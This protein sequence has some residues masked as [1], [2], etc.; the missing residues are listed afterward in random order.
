M[1]LYPVSVLQTPVSSVRLA[2]LI[3]AASVHPGPGSNPQLISEVRS[4]ISE[5]LLSEIWNPFSRNSWKKTS[6]VQLLSFNFQIAIRIIL[7]LERN[8][9]AKLPLKNLAWLLV[10]PR[11]QLL[12]KPATRCKLSC[13]PALHS[14]PGSFCFAYRH[15]NAVCWKLS[16]ISNT[17]K[18]F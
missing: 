13:F 12:W 8:S 4:Q 14:M 6:L 5:Y 15:F 7:F 2:C 11:R 3:H 16:S 10:F 9:H 1:A 18:Y 17:L